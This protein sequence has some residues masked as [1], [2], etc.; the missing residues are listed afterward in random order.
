MTK[1]ASAPLLEQLGRTLEKDETERHKMIGKIKGIVVFRIDG[2]V[3][4]LDLRPGQGSLKEGSPP[5]G[6]PRR[7][8]WRAR[9]RGSHGQ[10]R[11]QVVGCSPAALIRH[12][13]L[14]DGL[15][16]DITLTISDDNF[17]QLVMGKLGPQQA[18]LMR[19]LKIQ[20]SMAL[21]M[22]LQPILDAAAPKAKL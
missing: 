6:A 21:A 19:K 4:T 9:S 22:K 16:A 14:S 10:R 7:G 2:Q 11:A 5:G 20:G 1:K 3:W 18:F 15:K 8:R 13:F 17:A 12:P